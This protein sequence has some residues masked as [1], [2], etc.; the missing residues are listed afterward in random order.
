M[1]IASKRLEK[2]TSIQEDLI[3]QI[4]KDI[5]VEVN[6]KE[7]ITMERQNIEE[8]QQLLLELQKMGRFLKVSTDRS[9]EDSGI[10]QFENRLLELELSA[11]KIQLSDLDTD[12]V[13]I[14]ER[15]KRQ[16]SIQLQG[17]HED[18]A[19]KDQTRL[20]KPED[21]RVL[22]TS[23]RTLEEKVRQANA[24]KEALQVSLAT[25]KVRA[26]QTNEDFM[27]K[28]A[29]GK[30]TLISSIDLDQTL[31]DSIKMRK[32]LISQRS[33]QRCDE[34]NVR[35]QKQR[36]FTRSDVVRSLD[37]IR[38]SKR[39][40]E[41]MKYLQKIALL[42]LETLVEKNCLLENLV[43][44]SRTSGMYV[45]RLYDKI[46]EEIKEELK[47]EDFVNLQKQNLKQKSREQ[48][49]VEFQQ[50]TQPNSSMQG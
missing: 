34:K 45:K 29:S 14:S 7:T 18:K 37:S 35:G 50:I 4:E 17:L 10:L 44:K 30:D 32:T 49:S 15:V 39:K 24:E 31:S 21:L 23:T 25:E 26:H 46:P 19:L 13:A 47:M 27:R 1:E 42:L 16:E 5:Q 38:Q 8:Y 20:V 3:E 9:E 2:L 48:L 40:D 11:L 36:C 33:I 6:L 41:S 28:L 22:E 12:K 43:A